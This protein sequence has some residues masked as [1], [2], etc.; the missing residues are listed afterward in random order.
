MLLTVRLRGALVSQA[1]RDSGQGSVDADVSRAGFDTH[2]GTTTIDISGDVMT[3]KAAVGSE[4][5]IAVD[6]A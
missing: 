2:R 6:A 3:L 5:R 1:P 4:R